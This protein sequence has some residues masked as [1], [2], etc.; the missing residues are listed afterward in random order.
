MIGYEGFPDR[1]AL[2]GEIAQDLAAKLGLRLTG[3]EKQRLT[4]RY[5]E[6]GE[7]LSPEARAILS[8]SR[9]KI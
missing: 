7:R 4:K 9:P 8:Q 3:E 6:N 5:T 1:L 2:Q